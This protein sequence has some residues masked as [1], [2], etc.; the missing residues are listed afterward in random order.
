MK[1][2]LSGTLAVVVLTVVAAALVVAVCGGKAT[3]TTQAVAMATPAMTTITPVAAT[4]VAGLTTTTRAVTRT[5]AAPAELSGCEP[6]VG[7]MVA[8]EFTEGTKTVLGD[9]TR[10]RGGKAVWE[11]TASDPR[12]SGTLTLTSCNTDIRAGGTWILSSESVLANEGGAWVSDQWSAAV[13]RLADGHAHFTAFDVLEGTGEYQGLTLYCLNH[14]D[15]EAF[16]VDAVQSPSAPGVM[17]M[18]GWIQKAE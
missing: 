4:T 16:T 8:K 6:F 9:V 2:M 7:T 10:E 13:V 14:V 11:I 5:M 1:P 12:V 18:A 3:P 17:V 15:Q